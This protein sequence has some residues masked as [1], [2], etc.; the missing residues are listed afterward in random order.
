[1]QVTWYMDVMYV[2]YAKQY[3]AGHMVHRCHV[4]IVDVK[5]YSACHMYGMYIWWMSSSIVEVTWYMD[6]LSVQVT[7]Y[8]DVMFI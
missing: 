6:V 4:Y 7:W 2:V 1:M 8:M 5:Q 3:S